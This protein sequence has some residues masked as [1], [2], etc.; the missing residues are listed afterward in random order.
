MGVVRF[1]VE[2][3]DAGVRLDACVARALGCSRAEARRVLASGGV[4]VDGRVRGASHKGEI[5]QAGSEVEIPP[6][7]PPEG[8]VPEAE[9]ELPLEFVASGPGWLA[10]DK[11]PGMPVHPLHEGERGTALGAVVAR[12]PEVVGVGEGGLRSG[13]VHRLDVD[14]SGVLLFATD[15]AAWERIRIAFREHRMEKVYRAIVLGRLDGADQIDLPLEVARSRPARVR[16]AEGG[17]LVSIAWRTVETLDG[18]T[19]VEARPM[20]GF[21]HQI[22]VA[23]AHLGHPLVGDRRYGGGGEDDVS[24]ADRHMLHACR[25][26]GAGTEAEAP[27]PPDWSAVLARLRGLSPHVR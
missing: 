11:P 5:L 9:P 23:F 26:A 4:R 12:H 6:W 3:P 19:L 10:V 20:T 2:A 16:V 24:G 13:V 8:R 27:E 17:R 1:S 21:L 18:A 7:V 22:R 14:T 15:A 25:I